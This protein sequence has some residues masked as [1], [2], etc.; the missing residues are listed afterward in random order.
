MTFTV[1]GTGRTAPW[2]VTQMV[3]EDIVEQSSPNTTMHF[4]ATSGT[5]FDN[6]FGS[7]EGTATQEAQT[8]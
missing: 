7:K 6:K 8:F 3:I 1:T 2:N 5:T 4:I